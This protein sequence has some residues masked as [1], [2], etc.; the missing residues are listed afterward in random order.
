MK[1]DF[2]LGTESFALAV[3]GPTHRVHQSTPVILKA[4][5]RVRDEMAQ[6]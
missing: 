1:L 4:L 6:P 5:S 3:A 2:C